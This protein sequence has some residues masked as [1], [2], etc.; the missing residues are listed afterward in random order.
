MINQPKHTK[1][2]KS[3]KWNS[4]MLRVV[5]HFE[6]TANGKKIIYNICVVQNC[7]FPCSTPERS[8]LSLSLVCYIYFSR[9][10][11]KISEIFSHFDMYIIFVSIRIK[12]TLIQVNIN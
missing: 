10:V 12:T 4:F 2:N 9:T 11:Y 1:N 7:D 6:L 8:C 3:I 5:C